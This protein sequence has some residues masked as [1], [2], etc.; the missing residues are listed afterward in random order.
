MTSFAMGAAQPEQARTSTT[1][2][3]G[4]A[5]ARSAISSCSST[6]GVAART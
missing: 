5:T 1:T 6:A 4:H 3:L 2:S